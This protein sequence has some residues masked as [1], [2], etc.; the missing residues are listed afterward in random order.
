MKLFMTCILFCITPLA[1]CDIHEDYRVL[2][3]VNNK[4][5]SQIET[6]LEHQSKQNNR[7]LELE[8]INRF[9]ELEHDDRIRELERTIQMQSI[10]IQDVHRECIQSKKGTTGLRENSALPL[11]QKNTTVSKTFEDSKDLT[12]MEKVHI[13]MDHLNGRRHEKKDSLGRQ[14][15]RKRLLLSR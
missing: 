2:R 7:I 13:E 3:L 9:R 12:S 6:I 5:Q 8:R 11:L 14:N 4:M 15:D 10:Q 1:W